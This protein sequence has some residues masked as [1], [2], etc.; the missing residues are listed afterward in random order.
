MSVLMDIFTADLSFV[1]SARQLLLRRLTK[2]KFVKD[3]SDLLIVF[4]K[5]LRVHPFLI[6]MPSATDWIEKK[7]HLI[8]QQ[9]V[10]FLRPSLSPDLASLSSWRNDDHLLLER[11]LE[12][13]DTVS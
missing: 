9:F 11:Y 12:S 8:S 7:R 1:E 3:V 10:E 4:N 6:S 5:D 2:G 13:F